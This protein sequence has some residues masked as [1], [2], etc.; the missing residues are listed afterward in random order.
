MTTLDVFGVPLGSTKGKVV[1]RKMALEEILDKIRRLP[2]EELEELKKMLHD[3]L[4]R[5]LKD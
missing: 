3:E 4:F 2:I 5:G 1:E